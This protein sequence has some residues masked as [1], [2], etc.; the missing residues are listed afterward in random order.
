MPS[1]YKPR[2]PRTP[3]KRPAPRTP[4]P[5]ELVATSAEDPTADDEGSRHDAG[6]SND[7]LATVIVD[8]STMPLT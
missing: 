3:T 2:I 7:I 5:G 1:M 8:I 6:Q 4:D